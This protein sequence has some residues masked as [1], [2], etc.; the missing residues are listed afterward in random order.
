MT[1]NK[2]IMRKVFVS[3]LIS[4]MLAI[5]PALIFGQSKAGSILIRNAT[6]LTAVKGT[7]ENTDILVQNGKI[8]KIGKGLN[9]PAGSRRFVHGVHDPGDHEA[10][11]AGD[12]E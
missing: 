7:L 10:V 6:V 1:F 9:G 3:L 2:R 8:T 11:L 5:S 12:G 4:S